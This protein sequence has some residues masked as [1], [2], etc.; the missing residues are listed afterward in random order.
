[1]ALLSPFSLDNPEGLV[2]AGFLDRLGICATGAVQ[3]RKPL[4][5]VERRRSDKMDLMR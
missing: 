5:S 2:L 3:H 4:L 1:M